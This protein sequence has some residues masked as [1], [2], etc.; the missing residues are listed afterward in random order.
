MTSFP[1][2]PSNEKKK[3]KET[4][5]KEGEGGKE[6]K[7]KGNEGRKPVSTSLAFFESSNLP[8]KMLLLRNY[9]PIS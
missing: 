4:K 6:K 3:R 2:P 5:K 9:F 1:P 7:M 8:I